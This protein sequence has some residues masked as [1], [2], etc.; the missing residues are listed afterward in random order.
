M[1]ET[2]LS[3][4]HFLHQFTGNVFADSTVLFLTKLGNMGAVWVVLGLGLTC[5]RRTRLLGL[6][7]LLAAFF[8]SLLGN[9]FLKPLIDRQRPCEIVSGINFLIPCPGDGSFP[10]GHT[11]AGVAAATVFW[12]TRAPGRGLVLILAALIALTRLYLFVHF[13][14]DILGG[15]VFG[16]F[17]GWAAVKTVG[18]L[19][20]RLGLPDHPWM[21]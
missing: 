6:T 13:P 21:R 18:A 3:F 11:F 12:L 14:S 17:C 2:E 7:V 5:F 20:E 9:G 4:L 19:R 1:T 16:I 10:S 8:S 15:I